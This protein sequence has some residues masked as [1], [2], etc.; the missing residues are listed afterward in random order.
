MRT[1]APRPRRA[2]GPARP[3]KRRELVGEAPCAITLPRAATVLLIAGAQDRAARRPRATGR[4]ARPAAGQSPLD[5]AGRGGVL[6]GCSDASPRRRVR[7]CRAASGLARRAGAGRG[8][9]PRWCWHDAAWRDSRASAFVVSR[10][11]ARARR[12][13]AHDRAPV[14]AVAIVGQNGSGKTTLVGTS[15][16]CSGRLRATSWTT[17]RSRDVA[18]GSISWP[19]RSASPSRTLTTRLFERKVGARGR[20]RPT[21]SWAC[22]PS[23]SR[24][25]RRAAS[26]RSG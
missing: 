17:A 2:D 18:D 16:A 10:W 8:L 1:T 21:E 13:V 4:R 20:L 14:E 9:A 7:S 26:P 5:G 24:R 25:W 15:T 11:H 23:E 12:R 3:A 19:R 6:E 22:R